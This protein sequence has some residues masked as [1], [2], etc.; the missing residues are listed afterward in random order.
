MKLFSIKDF[1]GNSC[2][3]ISS[4]IRGAVSAKSYD[5]FHNCSAKIIK[6]SVFGVNKETGLARETL[7]FRNNNLVISSCDVKSIKPLELDIEQK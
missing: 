7:L 1:V 3:S 4:R 6:D 2:K 5:E